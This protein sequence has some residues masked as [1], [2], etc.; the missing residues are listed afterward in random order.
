MVRNVCDRMGV[1]IPG[2]DVTPPSLDGHGPFRANPRKRIKGE[3]DGTKCYG[4]YPGIPANGARSH[5]SGQNVYS[6]PGGR[7][8]QWVDSLLEFK[9]FFFLKE[10]QANALSFLSALS[11]LNSAS[12]EG[13]GHL[14]GSVSIK[15]K[16]FGAVGGAYVATLFVGMY[17]PCRGSLWKW[18]Q[19]VV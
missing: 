9:S 6:G 11:F 15:A 18:H 12:D 16:E 2:L 17:A 14:L 8:K 1:G 10:V 19:S 5:P 3:R 7:P 4:S 13:T